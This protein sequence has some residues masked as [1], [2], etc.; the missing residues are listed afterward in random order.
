MIK[1]HF[2]IILI[3]ACLMMQSCSDRASDVTPSDSGN[4]DVSWSTPYRTFC[5][6]YW[7]VVIIPETGQFECFQVRE[8]YGC[9]NVL[10]FPEP[11]AMANLTIDFDTLDIDPAN[12]TISVDVI[13]KHPFHDPTFTGF[14][15]RGVVFGPKVN[16]A[17]GFTPVMALDRFS[18]EPFGHIDGLLGVPNS[19]ADY[20]GSLWGYKFFCDDLGKD[21][22][23]IT[24]F[25]DSDNLENRAKFTN[26]TTLSRHYELD[27]YDVE[28]EFFVFNYAVYAN[29]DWP[30]GDPPIDLDDFTITTANS[31]EA[32]CC[33]ITEL[34]NSLYYDEGTGGGSISLKLEIWDWQKNIRDVTIES[35]DETTIP[36]TTEYEA[37]GP[38][39]T[40][41]SYIY[42]FIDISGHPQSEGDID[43]LITV[44][45]PMTFGQSWFHGLL[46]P[47]NLLYGEEIY[48]S[49][50]YTTNVNDLTGVSGIYSRN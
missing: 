5:P 42:E 1:K 17:D 44:T 15:V 49:F 6:G 36:E 25:S 24:F 2:V 28:N 21:D 32:F 14:D 39:G 13:L 31:Q 41:Y 27:W 3:F 26:G 16:N 12:Q 8:I 50:I 35:L 19:Y 37:A 4:R 7:E 38:G 47:S 18:G 45:D 29:Y 40:E 33:D 48:N 9:N 46:T 30:V 22:S 43:I 34:S 11:P 20:D 23:I 10:G